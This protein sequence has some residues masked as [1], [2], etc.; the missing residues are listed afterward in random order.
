MRP[1]PEFAQPFAPVLPTLGL[2]TSV[3]LA[4][5][6]ARSLFGPL[7][8]PISTHL[9]L[10]LATSAN[11]FLFLSGGYGSAV[12]CAGFISH[13]LGHQRTIVLS[14]GSIGLG[15]LGLA[16]SQT[17]LTFAFWT[18]VMGAGAGLYMPSSVVTI[19]EITPAA[20]W[21]RAFAVH[22][23]APNLA[24][25]LA[26]LLVE[27][28]LPWSGYAFLFRL[29]GGLC[30]GLA[31]WYALRGPRTRRLGKPPVFGNIKD[32]LSR[33]VFWIVALLFVFA[34][35]VEIG[36]YNLVPA[37]LVREK[38]VSRE[39]ANLILGGTRLVSLVFLPL[40]GFVISRIGYQRT[41]GLCLLG[42]ALATFL[43]GFGPLPW[44]VFMLCLQPIFVVCF[45]P[46]GFSVLALV[47]PQ[48]L[49]D[50]AVSLT[51]MAT[52]I[53]GAGLIPASLAWCGEGIGFGP[54]FSLFGAV[55]FACC[56]PAVWS[57]RIPAEGG[58]I[59]ST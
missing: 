23:L 54:A 3:F 18:T 34:V 8:L 24:L 55:M 1:H 31:L 20:H 30:L 46:V 15:L 25:L 53:L 45:F 32:I 29:L 14:V 7:L 51:V 19:T 50:L 11:L 6:L 22:E 48:A 5:F 17:F 21:G 47:C 57:L 26:P 2:L 28:F 43:A 36:V 58:N 10:T 59:T 56:L 52:S 13:L 49:S 33:P 40:T 38:G 35:G 4:N 27:L 9:N 39:T 44:T 41:L 42:A 16:A 12:F 37:F